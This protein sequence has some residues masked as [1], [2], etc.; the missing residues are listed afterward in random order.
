[1]RCGIRGEIRYWM[2]LGLGMLGRVGWEAK[3]LK[4]MHDGTAK[5]KIQTNFFSCFFLIKKHTLCKVHASGGVCG[6]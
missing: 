5:K 6:G 2:W 3:P 1:M 4:S